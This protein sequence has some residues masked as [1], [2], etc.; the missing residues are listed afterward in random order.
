ML[1]LRRDERE[2]VD[3]GRGP[4]GWQHRG[5]RL[6]PDSLSPHRHARDGADPLNVGH[7]RC[8]DDAGLL[9]AVH[10]QHDHA[11]VEG[12][13]LD[14]RHGREQRREA[15][16][17]DG[18][19]AV[20]RQAVEQRQVGGDEGRA[21]A[22]ALQAH[23][24][25]ELGARGVR[26]GGVTDVAVVRVRS[27]LEA[28]EHDGQ[29]HGDG[30]EGRREAADD[31]DRRRPDEAEEGVHHEAPHHEPE[32]PRHVKHDA[33]ARQ[34]EQHQRRVRRAEGDAVGARALVHHVTHCR[35]RRKVQHDGGRPEHRVAPPVHPAEEA[36]GERD[37]DP[38]HARDPRVG[39]EDVAV[40]V[41]VVA[42]HEVVDGEGGA[43][44]HRDGGKHEEE[45]RRDHEA[46][47]EEH[48]HHGGGADEDDRRRLPG[49][50][51]RVLLALSDVE[52]EVEAQAAV[53]LPAALL[54]GAEPER[55]AHVVQPEED[56]A[57]V[58]PGPEGDAQAAQGVVGRRETDE[59]SE[60]DDVEQHEDD[61]LRR[62]GRLLVREHR[63]RPQ[64][65]P[66]EG[67]R[68]ELEAAGAD[69]AALVADDDEGES[70]RVEVQRVDEDGHEEHRRDRAAA[71]Q[72]QH[73]RRE[74]EDR[75]GDA[76][77]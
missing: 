46:R 35:Q 39:A 37:G 70:E 18:L 27:R 19:V 42:V 38:P 2:A 40:D 29:R 6:Q 4:V 21:G 30:R 69:E 64:H 62:D 50:A 22:P 55:E 67:A 11:L 41:C 31:G 59:D 57:R 26:E 5:V 12:G 16:S 53:V 9:V 65:L 49:A 48:G 15:R 60:N 10:A 1:E 8:D 43:E 76:D 33:D 71:Q 73:R 68:A 74:Q 45:R 72:H 28:V 61:E 25:R 77:G 51:L 54:L 36:D 66:A 20:V 56:G 44:R 3:D 47:A 32:R 24:V 52:E 13:R 63:Q 14:E 17:G 75:R 7:E 58:H 34:H 23:G